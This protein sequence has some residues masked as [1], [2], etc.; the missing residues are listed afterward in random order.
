MLYSIAHYDRRVI[1]YI[2]GNSPPARIAATQTRRNAFAVDA[3][4]AA[5]ESEAIF[6]CGHNLHV[7]LSYSGEMR[8]G[9]DGV[10]WGWEELDHK[11]LLVIIAPSLSV[12]S[13][14]ND[15]K[16]MQLA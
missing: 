5:F 1:T 14:N 9:R 11:Q 15:P 16:R 7:H 10:K 4:F 13:H 3:P 8:R 6:N 12:P 2:T